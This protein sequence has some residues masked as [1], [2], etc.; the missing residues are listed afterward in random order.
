MEIFKIFKEYE[1]ENFKISYKD[2]INV[3]TITLK[4]NYM[5]SSKKI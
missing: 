5:K 2:E 3:G 1:D 4:T